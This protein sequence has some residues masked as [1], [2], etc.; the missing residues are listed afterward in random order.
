MAN[1]Q[2]ANQTDVGV[3]LLEEIK[4]E[5]E[6]GKREL[7]EISLLLEQSQ[8][9]VAKLAQRNTSITAH[10]QQVQ[11]QFDNLPR[12]DIRLAYDAAIEAQQRL[13]F[14][15]GQLEKLQS[16]QSHLKKHN[17]ALE[18][19]INLVDGRIA[20]V[21]KVGTLQATAESVEM[22]IEAQEAER[23]RLSRQMHDGPAQTL[24][25]FILQTEIAMR[26]FDMDPS[27]AKE[28]L[29]HLKAS[30][31]SAFQQVRDFIFELRPMMLDDLGLTPT[32]KRYVDAIK[33]HP[34]MEIQVIITGME[35]RFEPY[36][37]VML[38]RAIQE[39]VTNSVKHSQASIVKLYI[40][41]SDAFVKVTVD[42][43]GRGFD[44]STLEERG[45]MGIR[46][47]KDR[48]EKLGGFLQIDSIAGKG[49]RV[50]FQV[51]LAQ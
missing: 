28:E 43:N 35:R 29:A 32:V 6:Q 16:D 21:A 49:T 2:N 15:R 33:D 36:V 11:S 41:I 18:K 27:K 34:G 30:A 22:M 10:L 50:I 37:E 45:R 9:E 8:L 31:T 40:D 17:Q 38:F 46:I 47:I 42:D 25:N 48:V 7:T 1:E 12:A 14:M 26:L 4:G 51:P 24:S 13:F 3:Q 44:V 39:L 5:L 20:T 23:Q 19:C